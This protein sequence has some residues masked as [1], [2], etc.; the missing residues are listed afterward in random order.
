MPAPIDVSPEYELRAVRE[1]EQWRSRMLQGP[2]MFGWAAGKL[3]SKINSFIPEKA[4][5]AITAVIEKMTRGVLTGS[6]LIAPDLLRDGSLEAREHWVRQKIE[7]YRTTATVEGAVT[8]AGGIFLGIADFP[9]LLSI[10]LKLLVDIAALYGRSC[11][12]FSERLYLLQIFQLAFSSQQHR[13]KIFLEIET[14]NR[15][16]MP[17]SLDGFDWRTYQLEYRNYIDLAKLVQLIPVIGAPVGAV[18]NYRLIQQL[19]ET[20]MN[21]YRLRW[22]A[23][24]RKE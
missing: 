20:A 6:D 15:G 19:G 8:G 22:F 9:L 13:R 2:G 18:V 21:A 11:G 4:H 10:K 24:T 17:V 3:Q 1:V 14:W 5:V 23:E 16:S 12:E 7:N